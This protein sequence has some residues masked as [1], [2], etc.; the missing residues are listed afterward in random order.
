M[1][2]DMGPSRAGGLVCIHI[3]VGDR[4]APLRPRVIHTHDTAAAGLHGIKGAS[5]NVHS[6]VIRRLTLLGSSCQRNNFRLRKH[7]TEIKYRTKKTAAQVKSKLDASISDG[8][9]Q[10]IHGTVGC[11]KN[12]YVQFLN[13]IQKYICNPGKPNSGR[14]AN[15]LSTYLYNMSSG[16]ASNHNT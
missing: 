9:I 10:H 3:G 6:S 13:Y 14:L 15:E 8:Q 16:A 2:E 7:L 11:C 4:V 5:P 1:D 12:Y